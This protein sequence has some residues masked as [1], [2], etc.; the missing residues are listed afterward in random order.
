MEEKARTEADGADVTKGD[1]NP[2]LTS[3]T[4][5]NRAKGSDGFSKGETG[6]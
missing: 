6:A 1:K 2:K 4:E 5:Y 3:Y